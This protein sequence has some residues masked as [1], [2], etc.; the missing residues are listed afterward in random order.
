VV[1]AVS[2]LNAALKSCTDD[3]ETVS[4]FYVSGNILAQ[5]WRYKALAVIKRQKIFNNNKK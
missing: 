2:V 4:A 5:F 1:S 3:E